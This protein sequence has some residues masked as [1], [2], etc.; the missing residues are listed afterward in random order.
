MSTKISELGQ[1]AFIDRLT[2][3]IKIKNESTIL[4]VGDDAAII[5]NNPEFETLF[6][7]ELFLEGIHFDLAYTPLAHL[8]YKIV[9]ASIMDIYAMGGDPTHITISLGIT[10]RFSVETIEELYSGI[11][12]A[13]ERYNIDF[14]GGD[15]TASITGLSIATSVIG[16]VLKGRSIKRSTAKNTDLICV[17]GNLGAAYMGLQLLERERAVF[18]GEKGE[19][20]QPD[21]LGKEYIIERQL[22]PEL[23]VDLINSIRLLNIP[24]TSMID[25]S[26]GLA[27]ELLQI[28]KSSNVGVRIYEDKLP[29]DYQTAVMAEEMNMNVVTVALNGGDDYELLFTAPLSMLDK[30]KE[31]KDIHIIG[32]ITDKSLG[33]AMITRDGN[34]IELS[35]PGWVKQEK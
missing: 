24:I 18:L 9:I 1:F 29:I 17:S 7:S 21:F 34:E 8:G 22:K 28:S 32:H 35:A 10:N 13:C 6:S 5:S 2:S 33:N 27:S 4:G 19:N 25:I 20:V 14:V 3:T 23:P 30:L 12:L 11:N 31:I 16:K 15:S 26:D